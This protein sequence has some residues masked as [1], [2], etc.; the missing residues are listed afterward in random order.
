MTGHTWD[1]CRSARDRAIRTLEALKQF[2]AQRRNG[3]EPSVFHMVTDNP[4]PPNIPED[5]PLL[6]EGVGREQENYNF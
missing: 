5:E 4:N 2:K 3:N 1:T 6:Q